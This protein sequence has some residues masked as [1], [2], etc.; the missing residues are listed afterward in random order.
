MTA[1]ATATTTT[2]APP[3]VGACEVGAVAVQWRGRV[4]LF[5]RS[6]AVAHDQ[7][8]WHCITGYLEPGATP[9]QQALTE[10]HEETGLGVV[11]LESFTTGEVLELA[12]GSGRPWTV[13]TFRAVTHR[14]RLVLNE[15]HDAYRWV[16]V[17]A[18][19]R[20]GNQVG[21]LGRALSAAGVESARKID[22][23]EYSSP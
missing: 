20:F 21:W 22:S 6:A 16:D 15:E 4:G 10:L 11:D 19:A 5:R 7:G 2:P 13:H 3:R 8:L 9:A 17:K 18:V 1:T 23:T 14:R 12:D